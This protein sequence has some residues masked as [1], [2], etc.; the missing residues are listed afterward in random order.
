MSKP[1]DTPTLSIA[2][3]EGA[4]KLENRSAHEVTKTLTG[5][6]VHFVKTAGFE[7]KT[8]FATGLFKNKRVRVDV[9]ALRDGEPVAFFEIDRTHKGISQD[10]LLGGLQKG[11][12]A[13]WVRWGDPA[14]LPGSRR[15]TAHVYD[16]VETVTLPINY[17]RSLRGAVVC[18]GVAA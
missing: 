9:A 15:H 2:L 13:I 8:E 18:P 3:E 14:G 10:K 17:R 7:A 12:Q 4:R 5:L 6:V 16:G 1:I 11:I